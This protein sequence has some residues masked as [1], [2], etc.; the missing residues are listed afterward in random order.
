ML[1]AK[2][3]NE[4]STVAIVGLSPDPR[5]PSYRVAS[6]LLRHGYA[7]IPVN[8]ETQEIFGKTSYPIDIQTI[9]F[10]K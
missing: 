8:P 6:Y 5:R 3:L 10:Q 2:I 9:S 7:V 4:Y 1:E